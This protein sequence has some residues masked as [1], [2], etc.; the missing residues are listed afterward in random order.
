MSYHTQGKSQH[1][2][3][4]QVTPNVVRWISFNFSPQINTL[5]TP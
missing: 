3:L 2:D 4:I 1:A 5:L